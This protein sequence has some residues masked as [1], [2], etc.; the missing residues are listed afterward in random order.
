MR[1]VL[2]LGVCCLLCCRGLFVVVSRVVLSLF[3]CPVCVRGCLCVVKC[4]FACGVLVAARC[5]LDVL[6][7]WFELCA[8]FRACCGLSVVSCMLFVV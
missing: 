7:V 3:L 5:V 4:L 8:C 1:R 6:V 2:F